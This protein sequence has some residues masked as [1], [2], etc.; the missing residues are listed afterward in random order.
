MAGEGHFPPS[1]DLFNPI[2][3]GAGIHKVRYLYDVGCDFSSS[4]NLEVYSPENLE[5]LGGGVVVCEDEKV[6]IRVAHHQTLRNCKWI[7]NGE[8]LLDNICDSLEF[9][10][11]KS[12]CYSTYFSAID[13]NGCLS[14]SYKENIVCHQPKPHADFEMDKTVAST[15]DSVRFVSKAI[16]GDLFEWHFGDGTSSKEKNPIHRY[17][18]PGNFSVKLIVADQSGHCKDELKKE[19]VII[20]ERSEKNDES[21]Q[22][23][24]TPISPVNGNSFY[25]N[26]NHQ[27]PTSPIQK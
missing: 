19:K 8:Q 15:M 13:T 4:L 16:K 12:Q 7:I 6:N 21:Y 26:L 23:P 5:I 2:K 3:A 9:V 27:A 25:G 17:A 10:P 14:A 20:V 11:A 22:R 24:L 1:G 18:S